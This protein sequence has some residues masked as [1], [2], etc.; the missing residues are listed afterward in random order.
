MIGNPPIPV[1]RGTRAAPSILVGSSGILATACRVTSAVTPA[2][3]DE[4]GAAL[5][6]LG[7]DRQAVAEFRQAERLSPAQ[8][9]HQPLV[10]A[11]RKTRR[12]EEEALA[13]LDRKLGDEYDLG[14]SDADWW[15]REVGGDGDGI[16]RTTAA[17]LDAALRASR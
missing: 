13:I 4:A 11:R 12:R 17:Q 14:V 7:E 10:R 5:T 15:A 3:P 9:H 1:S 16:V 8:V 2:P 6:M